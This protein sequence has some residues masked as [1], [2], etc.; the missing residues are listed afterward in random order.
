M[1]AI[2]KFKADLKKFGGSVSNLM[3]SFYKKNE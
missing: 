1:G 2:N 3:A